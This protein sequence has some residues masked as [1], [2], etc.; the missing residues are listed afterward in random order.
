MFSDCGE[1]TEGHESVE[2]A[3]IALFRWPGSEEVVGQCETT[4]AE[5][6]GQLSKVCQLTRVGV[7]ALSGQ[8]CVQFHIIDSRL[9][10]AAGTPRALGQ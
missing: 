7:W 8:G 10:T 6:L 1:I 9:V 4:V 3:A 5:F 2:R